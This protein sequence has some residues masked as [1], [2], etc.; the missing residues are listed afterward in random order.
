MIP[1]GAV[2]AGAMAMSGEDELETMAGGG[3]IRKAAEAIR[4]AAK[5][6]GEALDM[7][8][9]GRKRRAAQQGFNVDE[10]LYHGTDKSFENFIPKRGLSGTASYLTP[11]ADI[12]SAYAM[13]DVRGKKR[14]DGANILP[15][16]VRGNI[17]SQ[18]DLTRGQEIDIWKAIEDYELANAELGTLKYEMLTD[19]KFPSMSESLLE[20]TEEEYVPDFVQMMEKLAEIKRTE[21]ILGGLGYTGVRGLEELINARNRPGLREYES[22]AVFDPKNIR[23]VNARFNPLD[24]DSSNILSGLGAA[25]IGAGA[26]TSEDDPEGMSKGGLVDKLRSAASSVKEAG[27]VYKAAVGNMFSPWE[28]RIAEERPPGLYPSD[29][30]YPELQLR[31]P[32]IVNLAVGMPNMFADM[33][34]LFGSV[35]DVAIGDEVPDEQ[36]ARWDKATEAQG[37]YEEDMDKFLRSYTGKSMDELS[38]PMSAVLGVS[39]AAAQPGII[40]A[41]VVAGLPWLARYLSHLAEFAT[42]VTV[43]SPGAMLT[44]AGF[45]AG[46]RAL[47]ALT[48]GDDLEQMNARYSG[49]ELS[50][51]EQDRLDDYLQELLGKKDGMAETERLAGGGA[52]RKAAEAI[53]AANK[54][55]SNRPVD[56]QIGLSRAKSM[57]E[58]SGQRWDDVKQISTPEEYLQF[59]RRYG[60]ASVVSERDEPSDV[61]HRGGS[62]FYDEETGKPVAYAT[63]SASRKKPE[64]MANGGLVYDANR[65]NALAAQLMEPV[66]LS[67]GGP[68]P[69]SRI[70]RAA[71]AIRGAATPPREIPDEQLVSDDD[72]ATIARDLGI[73]VDETIIPSDAPT[74]PIRRTGYGRSTIRGAGR[75]TIP[76]I[77]DDPRLIVER[78]SAAVAPES[79]A[80][81]QL[82]GVTREDLAKV[83][84]E[85]EPVVWSPPGAPARPRGTDYAGLVMQPAN[86]QR[87]VDILDEASESP[88]RAGMTG[89]YMLDPAYRRLVELVGEDEAKKLFVDMN[90]L[91]GVHSANAAVANELTRGTAMNWLNRENRLSDYVKYG[92]KAGMEGA[93]ADMATIPGHLAHKTAHIIPA[94][95]Y[96]ETGELSKEA[97]TPAY[98]TASN[99][100]EIGTNVNFPVGDAHFVRAIGLSDVRPETKDPSA[101]F[102]SWSM[103]EAMQLNDWFTSD[104]ARRAGLS[105]VSAQALLWGALSPTTGVKSKIG[106]PKLEIL[107]DLIMQTAKRLN[108]SPEEARDMVL[109]GRAY[110]GKAAGGL[111]GYKQQISGEM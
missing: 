55:A 8:A 68:P 65:I 18:Q 83:A 26:L 74:Q 71:A 17:L 53:G 4:G 94:L 85:R 92:A 35:K 109:L 19:K 29:W 16:Y 73:D 88:L 77:Y 110:A 64:G 56:E 5:S 58:Q 40:P 79:E 70:A 41:K 14:G 69:R 22:I 99:P 104:V 89:W 57:V 81:Q 2:G 38:G 60:L 3:A 80:M 15:A 72:F 46:I 78:A 84:M 27:N 30:E 43:A 45:N 33:R 51:E 95:R 9:E 105:G 50:G 59:Q 48:D 82:F 98:I 106:A 86:T 103:P 24:I 67:E 63:S 91:T 47:P 37:R 7:S 21:D 76:G 11:D 32:G 108:V 96:L 13:G 100:P 34:D 66:R 28:P 44:G 10:V 52:I 111:I 87:L 90:T 54:S 101:R 62:M 107:A 97:K 25:A 102:A 75:K 39:E 61:F 42:P 23:S 6:A 93:P 31:R 1:V 49:R 12:A 36:W 20:T